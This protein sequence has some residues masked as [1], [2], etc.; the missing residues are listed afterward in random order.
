MGDELEIVAVYDGDELDRKRKA[1][2][3]DRGDFC[4]LT[5]ESRPADVDLTLDRKVRAFD[6]VS[7]TVIYRSAL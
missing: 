1:A 2:A 6:S 5:E 4:D 3:I 7:G